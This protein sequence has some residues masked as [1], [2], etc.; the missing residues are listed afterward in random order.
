LGTGA[1]FK[2]Q[3]VMNADRSVKKV[4]K[5]LKAKKIDSDLLSPNYVADFAR[6]L[7]ISLTSE[8]VVYISNTI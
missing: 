2:N 1:K 4:I 8:Q 5:L 7:G 3:I 6:N